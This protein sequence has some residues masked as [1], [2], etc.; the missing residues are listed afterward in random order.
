[1]G[2]M[3]LDPCRGAPDARFV[4]GPI[5]DPGATVWMRNDQLSRSRVAGCQS[6]ESRARPRVF[7][8]CRRRAAVGLFLDL[9]PRTAAF[10][11][12]ARPTPVRWMY[13]GSLFSWSVV[14]VLHGSAGGLG[15]LL[16]LR[17]LLGLRRRLVFRPTAR[18]WP[19]GFRGASGPGESVCT[20]RRSTS[21]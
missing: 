3:L 15:S 14:T 6:S 18:F 7:A 5:R 1:M 4:T 2:V 13:T 10:G 9:L 17:L 8:C 19:G 20:P 21:G 11:V 12:A 16:G